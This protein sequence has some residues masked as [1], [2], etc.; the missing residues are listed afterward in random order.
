[1]LVG[2]RLFA[3]PHSTG[4][5][6]NVKYTYVFVLQR[7]FSANEMVFEKVIVAVKDKSMQHGNKW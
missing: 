5:V 3:Q 7:G 2:M 6:S 4:Q 1:M